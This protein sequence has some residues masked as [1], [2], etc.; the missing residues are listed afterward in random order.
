MTD[1]NKL[2]QDT[3]NKLFSNDCN[4][5]IFIYTP[6]KV[7]STTL[8][9]S[10]RVSLGKTYNIIHIHDDVML[11]VLTG[12]KV[13]VNELI[14][15]IASIGKNIYIIDV[16]R[17]CVE[18][19]M[20]EFF[21]KLSPYHF[22]NTDENI[23][24][25][26]IKRIINRFN[27]L[28][29]HLSKGEHYFDN[30]D[31]PEPI[32]FDFQKKYTIQIV[33]NVKYIKLRL[34]D[35]PIWSDILSEIL[36]TKIV[37]IHDYQTTNKEIGKLYTRFKNEYTL[38][39][40]YYEL[41]KNDRYFNFYYS[42]EEREK[43]LE[44]WKNRLSEDFIPYTR[45]EYDFY[46]NLYLEN[47]FYNDIQFDHYIDNGCFCKNCSQ[48]RKEIYF[49][50]LNGEKTTDKI[51]HSDVVIEKRKKILH[52][53]NI[54]KSVNNAKSFLNKKRVKSSKFTINTNLI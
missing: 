15:Y 6:P 34:C 8:V 42:D 35:S 52:V 36:K 7:G 19:K 10:L 23:S 4:N 37:L 13:K 26:N 28:Y 17:T 20:S 21:E 51:L 43:Y 31:I 44:T 54:I 2:I 41:I 53:I 32:P 11:H 38:P 22:N 30:Y 9:T 50:A 25:Y 24:E 46:V 47:Q 1:R 14:K 33:D 12:I 49:K 5:Y 18:R 39:K 45:E 16:Y 29:P 27:K 40:N 3:F 48:K